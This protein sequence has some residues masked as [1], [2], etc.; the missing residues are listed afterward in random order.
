MSNFKTIFKYSLG[1]KI[2]DLSTK[3]MLILFVVLGL[4]LPIGFTIVSELLSKTDIMNVAIIESENSNQFLTSFE[5]NELTSTDFDFEVIGKDI[6]ADYE[7]EKCKKYDT[8]INIEK[9]LIYSF[10][11]NNNVSVLQTTF[12][13]IMQQQYLVEN[14]I[15]ESV[16]NEFY[17]IGNIAIEYDEKSG[18]FDYNLYGITMGLSIGLYMLL[19]FLLQLIGVEIAEEKS[20]RAM[21]IIMTSCSS[22]T[23]MTAKI[24]SNISYL[25]ILIFT[26]VIS[27]ILGIVINNIYVGNNLFYFYGIFTM[28]NDTISISFV[29]I[30]IVLSLVAIFMTSIITASIASTATSSQ[31]FQVTSGPIIMFILIPYL[32]VM[33]NVSNNILIP[34]G[35]VPIMSAFIVPALLV[36][37]VV[38]ILY[39]IIVCIINVIFIFISIK[40]SSRLYKY[41]VLNYSA[42]PFLTILKNAF[43]KNN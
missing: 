39:V 41:G 13:S 7:N 11:S 30:T 5:N 24:M 23:H 29:I 34:L 38:S 10:K 16:L 27:G 20:N 21:E 6:C 32:L 19:I 15:N 42:A 2:K 1:L 8:I 33:F 43:G 3:V 31:D 25:A 36:K 14:N 17:E 12:A 26:A 18:A 37:D 22:Q 28:L 40:F 35:F 9:P 4:F